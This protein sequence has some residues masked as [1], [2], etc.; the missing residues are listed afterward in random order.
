MSFAAAFEAFLDAEA[1][2]LRDRVPSQFAR[3]YRFPFTIF[4][5]DRPMVLPDFNAFNALIADIGARLGAIGMTD[6]SVDMGTPE[7]REDDRFVVP[8]RWRMQL[9]NNWHPMVTVEY[10][11]RGSAEDFYLEMNRYSDFS[12]PQMPQWQS[13][14]DFIL[15][16]AVATTEEEDTAADVVRL[17][18][19]NGGG[20]AQD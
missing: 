14:A 19:A 10:F 11:G 5:E 16:D 3:R 9:G 8:A 12:I 4:V 1:Q 20:H 15:G 6:A 17:Y 2:N 18:R 7:T 13:V